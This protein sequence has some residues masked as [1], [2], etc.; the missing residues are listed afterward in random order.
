MWRVQVSPDTI[1]SLMES[2]DEGDGHGSE[3]PHARGYQEEAA[4]ARSD[5]I[6]V[7]GARHRRRAGAAGAAAGFFGGGSVVRQSEKDEILPLPEKTLGEALL[8]KERERERRERERLARDRERAPPDRYLESG[9]AAAPA[10]AAASIRAVSAPEPS[11]WGSGTPLRTAA[12][13]ERWEEKLD[14]AAAAGRRD[15]GLAEGRAARQPDLS[16]GNSGRGTFGSVDSGGSGTPERLVG[17]E[18]G[19]GWARV[20]ALA[21]EEGADARPVGGG[22]GGQ[23]GRVMAQGPDG[24]GGEGSVVGMRLGGSVGG[25]DEDM[26]VKAAPEDG[27][28]TAHYGLHKKVDS[29]TDAVGKEAAGRAVELDSGNDGDSS[30]AIYRAD[31]ASSDGPGGGEAEPVGVQTEEEGLV[32]EVGACE[33]GGGFMR[34]AGGRLRE[35]TRL[36]VPSEVCVC[37]CLSLSVC[38]WHMYVCVCV[39]ACV[40]ECSYLSIYLSVCLS[41][42][43]SV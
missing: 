31:G 33:V 32:P 10:A 6:T 14:S 42:D 26:T 7:I 2:D 15:V 12:P 13:A 27:E 37:V 20:Q 19:R 23:E 40:R 17:S 3:H 28:A 21:V 35:K 9:A 25:D 22:A 24:L 41:I 39:C 11:A 18:R 8:E 43:L 36:R 5:A 38:V 34:G 4:A 1:R 30:M 29:A 16:A